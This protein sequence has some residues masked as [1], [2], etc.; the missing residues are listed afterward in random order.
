MMMKISLSALLLLLCSL[1][2]AHSLA[3]GGDDV[4]ESNNYQRPPHSLAEGGDVQVSSSLQQDG[5]A[6]EGN[7]RYGDNSCQLF[8]GLRDE[9]RELRETVSTLWSQLQE[10]KRKEQVAFGA[11]LG[12][13]GQQGP[14]N[15]EITLVYKDVFVNAGNAYNPTTGIFT[16]PV[17]GVYYFS[18]SGH[19]SSS[20]S[21]GLRLFK[22]GQQMVTVYNHA[23]GNR[24]ETAT[25]GMT[26][27][28]E[29]GDHVYMRLR[30]NTWLFDN[31]NDH[32]TFI[33]HLLF[34]L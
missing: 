3:E 26:L 31:E 10:Q 13:Y 30:A 23:A 25:N 17:R 6:V 15:T 7:M 11:S 18:F 14:Y 2:G 1:C 9:V 5:G 20:R 34:P 16:A 24:P 28:L 12:P 8:I 22:N 29:T 21:M 19:H 33:G 32:S 27:Q 4:S